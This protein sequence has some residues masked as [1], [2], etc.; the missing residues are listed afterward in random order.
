VSVF[1]ARRRSSI[2][3]KVVKADIAAS[4]GVVHVTDRVN[5]PD[6]RQ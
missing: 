5:L 1:K 2:D 3:A 6:G 4:N